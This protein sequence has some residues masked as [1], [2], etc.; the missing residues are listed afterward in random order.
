M[1]EISHLVGE[2]LTW[3]FRWRMSFFLHEKPVV[4]NFL[5]LFQGHIF[6][7][8]SDRWIW[9]FAKDDIFSVSFA[10]HDLLNI[11]SYPNLSFSSTNLILPFIWGSWP[12]INCLK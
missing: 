4:A 8:D 10:Y 12:L 7:L 6:S 2:I 5:A 11:S 3:D 9:K 1:R